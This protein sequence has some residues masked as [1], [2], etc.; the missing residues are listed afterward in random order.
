MIMSLI[1]I[2]I[3]NVTRNARRSLIT[4]AAVLIGTLFIIFARGLLNGLQ[5]SIIASFTETQAGDLQLHHPDYL[6]ANEAL[7]L[8]KTFTM[9]DDFKKMMGQVPQIEDY[10]GRIQ[11]SGMVSNG[12]D[13]TLF[14]GMGVDPENEYKVCPRN[15]SRVQEGK[16]VQKDVPNGIVL[17]KA[18]ADALH[19]KVGSELTLL[20]N[21]SKGSLNAMDVTVV[22]ISNILLPGIGNKIVHVPLAMAQKLLY[23]ENQVT[24]VVVGIKD[25]DEV[26]N[27]EADLQK[28]LSG[29]YKSL[30][31][32]PNTWKAIGKFYLDAIA[33]QNAVLRY[34]IA[35]LFIVMIAGIINTML[36]S[37]FERVREIGTLMAIGV[38]RLKILM[39]FLLE[40]IA[41]GAM[42]ALGGVS[43]G[44]IAVAI[45]ERHGLYIPAM[46]TGEPV[47][48]F[49]YIRLEYMATVTGIALTT[50]IFA[51]LYPAWRASRLRP[52]EALR[53]L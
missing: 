36:M 18:L 29:P 34:I 46:G 13:T 40:S 50:A 9:G 19:A 28:Q 42:G 43:L 24:E 35:V 21:T 22:G 25:L 38:K 48:I 51:A 12:D 53:T 14:V 30:N 52:A 32:V 20:V 47:V 49:P 1:R 2:S 31:L 16:P 23:M 44:G 10:A 17:G 33:V 27:V 6:A 3:R 41:L 39:M 5:S 45:L 26:D 4:A 37:V 15:A 8:D 7:P 11:F